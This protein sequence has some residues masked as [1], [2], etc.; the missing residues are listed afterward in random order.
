MS[1]PRWRLRRPL[2]AERVIATPVPRQVNGAVAADLLGLMYLLTGLILV[3]RLGG[4][5]G[6]P[7]V[8]LD[9]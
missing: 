9:Q 2:L 6:P 8:I 7:A 1:F 3:S 4:G 5:V